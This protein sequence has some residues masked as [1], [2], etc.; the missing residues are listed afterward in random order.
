[1]FQIPYV[2]ALVPPSDATSRMTTSARGSVENVW[3]AESCV[4]KTDIHFL[5]GNVLTKERIFA[6]K[7]YFA[8]RSYRR[9]KEAFHAEFPISATTL[10]DS[11]ILHLVGMFEEAGNIQ[12]K[13][14]KGRLHMAMTVEHV[15]EVHELV[16]QNPHT[17][18]RNNFV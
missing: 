4:V 6:L 11:L 9:V 18:T 5:W 14:Q 10:S 7:T 13:L 8:T 12:D 15:E 1:M 17:L 2:A 16:A 3:C